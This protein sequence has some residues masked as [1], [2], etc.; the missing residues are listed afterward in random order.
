MNSHVVNNPSGPE[1]AAR[2]RGSPRLFPSYL[3]A[4]AP[5]RHGPGR[6]MGRQFMGV[7][8]V[9]MCWHQSNT[10]LLLRFIKIH[11]G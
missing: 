11:Y 8:A 6:S 9:W 10:R 4:G 5:A 3:A 2:L 7:W 1:P